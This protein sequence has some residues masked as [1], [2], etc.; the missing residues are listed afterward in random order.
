MVSKHDGSCD[1]HIWANNDHLLF[2]EDNQKDLLIS[3][4]YHHH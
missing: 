2:P 4:E 1:E 3:L